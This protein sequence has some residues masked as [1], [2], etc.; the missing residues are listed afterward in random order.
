MALD[1]DV[2]RSET[3]DFTICIYA[4]EANDRV[5]V[6][7]HNGQPCEFLINR[8]A[9]I[10]GIVEMKQLKSIDEAIKIAGRM[11]KENFPGKVRQAIIKLDGKHVWQRENFDAIGLNNITIG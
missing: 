1:V 11:W 8:G 4:Y 3:E 6:R 7:E 10:G 5:E 9:F 2:W